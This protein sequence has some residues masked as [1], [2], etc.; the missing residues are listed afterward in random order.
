M[1]EVSTLSTKPILPYVP[2]SFCL[3]QHLNY[4]LF[5]IFI[6]AVFSVEGVRMQKT[7]MKRLIRSNSWETKE[8]I[9]KRA[10][11]R[12]IGT[13]LQGNGM[14]PDCDTFC[15]AS[16]VFKTSLYIMLYCENLQQRKIWID[17]IKEWIS[18]P[19]PKLLMIA[20][21]W[22]DWKR[23]SAVPSHLPYQPVDQGLK[24]N[25]MFSRGSTW[26]RKKKGGGGAH[27]SSKHTQ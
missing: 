11:K 8:K 6:S 13:Q 24:W 4:F 18:L 16:K 22:K 25:Q 27:P 3:D 14:H 23:I 7:A 15:M 9:P 5:L 12:Q 20:S 19:I 17:H 2:T 10:W 26:E 1:I 21:H